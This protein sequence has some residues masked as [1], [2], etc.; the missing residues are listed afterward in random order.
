MEVT[1]EYAAHFYGMFIQ[2]HDDDGKH[3]T[4]TGDRMKILLLNFASA[5]FALIELFP[6][7][8]IMLYLI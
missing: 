8:G 7:S 4:R 1:N 2:H 3:M 5:K 6:T